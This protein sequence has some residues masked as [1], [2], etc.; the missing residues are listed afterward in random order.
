MFLFGEQMDPLA[1]NLPMEVQNTVIIGESE[2]NVV[3]GQSV[4]FE[5]EIRTTNSQLRSNK[6]FADLSTI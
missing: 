1:S 6:W 4:S 2:L 5:A 3:A